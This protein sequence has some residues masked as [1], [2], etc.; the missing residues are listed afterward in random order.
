MMFIIF[1]AACDEE[2]FQYKILLKTTLRSL[3]S[4]QQFLWSMEYLQPASR[5]SAWMVS[6]ARSQ[7]SGDRV[8]SRDITRV[9]R[10]LFLPSS[11]MH[12]TNT[13][14]LSQSVSTTAVRRL[15]PLN[16]VSQ[17]PSWPSATISLLVGMV[18]KWP[19]LVHYSFY[20]SCKI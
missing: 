15:T 1:L 20:I 8:W 12:C 18:Q 11:C 6:L 7:W 3:Q 14:Q 4:S 2:T 10:N 16:S 17:S 19:W 5:S 13:A 9:E